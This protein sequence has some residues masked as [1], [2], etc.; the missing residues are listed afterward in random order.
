MAKITSTATLTVYDPDT[1]HT[2]HLV[3]V[4]GGTTYV[5]PKPASASVSD[6]SPAIEEVRFVLFDGSS[7]SAFERALKLRA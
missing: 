1:A 5:L 3:Q 7:F 4:F 6:A 2:G